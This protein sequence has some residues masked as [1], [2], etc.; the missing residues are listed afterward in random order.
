[1]QIMKESALN[2]NYKYISKIKLKMSFGRLSHKSMS[3]VLSGFIKGSTAFSQIIKRVH[4][5]KKVGNH[6]AKWCS[7]V[8][9][10]LHKLS[11]FD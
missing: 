9:T 11:M 2:V 1:M 10:H 7:S 5:A 6:C 3:R 4:D 8:F